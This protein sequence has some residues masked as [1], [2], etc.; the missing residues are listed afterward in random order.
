MAF[1]SIEHFG[2]VLCYVLEY[3]PNFRFFVKCVCSLEIA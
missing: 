1:E 3:R 2:E